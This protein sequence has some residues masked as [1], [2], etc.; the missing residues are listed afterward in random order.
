MGVLL[1]RVFK[2]GATV[3]RNCSSSVVVFP[4]RNALLVGLKMLEP[5]LPLLLSVMPARRGALSLDESILTLTNGSVGTE[6]VVGVDDLT[7]AWN[8]VGFGV[9]VTPETVSSL[10]TVG[11]TKELVGISECL[12]YVAVR[13]RNSRR[14]VCVSVGSVLT[15][16]TESNG[17]KTPD[18]FLMYLLVGPTVLDV[19][20][21]TATLSDCC[22]V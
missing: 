3:L 2:S 8:L 20:I 4:P 9:M 15:L 14:F 18:F 12:L 21:E 19:T 22:F 11:W 6:R 1:P 7:L 16:G 10:A 13:G 5:L 17:V